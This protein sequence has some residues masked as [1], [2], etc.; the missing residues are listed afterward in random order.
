[1]PA[2][3]APLINGRRY[4]FSSIELAIKAG[5]TAQEIVTDVED[6]SYNE[7]LVIAYKQG[8]SRVPLGSTAGV[9]E[10]QEGSLLLGKSS[11]TNLIQTIGPG[12][13]GINAVILAS[14]FDI[15]EVLTVDTIVCRLFT[16]IEDAHS[17]S[18][19]ALKQSVKFMPLTPILRNGISGMLN[20]V[21]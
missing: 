15:G 14:Y 5:A 11:V 18:P 8:T 6:I 17:Y 4:S 9:W 3:P 12:W 2:A 13:M 1:M 19:D 10:A 20:R 21:F 16:G 7:S